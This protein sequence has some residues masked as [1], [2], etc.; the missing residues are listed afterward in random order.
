MLWNHSFFLIDK[1]KVEID[2]EAQAENIQRIAKGEADVTL[3]KA[4][5]EAQG[6]Y[7]V[8]TK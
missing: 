8:L 3:F 7:E 6:L 2:A 5:A 1:R 4:Q